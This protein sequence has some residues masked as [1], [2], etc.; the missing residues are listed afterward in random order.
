[1]KANK[2][3]V[4]RQLEKSLRKSKKLIAEAKTQEAQAVGLAMIEGYLQAYYF[5]GIINR[6]EYNKFQRD[7]ESFRRLDAYRRE[8]KAKGA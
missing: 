1:M 7:M 6:E 4:M 3:A 2:E 5:S 8:L